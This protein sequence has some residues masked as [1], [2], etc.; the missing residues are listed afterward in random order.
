MSGRLHHPITIFAR[1]LAFQSPRA[2]WSARTM[3]VLLGGKPQR[4]DRSQSPQVKSQLDRSATSFAKLAKR[5]WI[6][7]VTPIRPSFKLFVKWSDGGSFA[8]IEI[9]AAEAGAFDY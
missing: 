9:N 4:F 5:A 1:R 7:L 3:Q 6:E 8:L 2:I